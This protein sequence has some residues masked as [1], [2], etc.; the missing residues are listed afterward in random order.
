MGK[1]RLAAC[2]M[3]LSACI[4]L[5]P[6]SSKAATTEGTWLFGDDVAVNTFDCNYPFCG[7]VVWT[8]VQ[9]PEQCGKTVVWGLAR[10]GQ[11]KWDDGHF[12]DPGDG[13]TYDLTVLRLADGKIEAKL[14]NPVDLSGRT[15]T[16]TPIEPHSLTGWCPDQPGE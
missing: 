1:G 8:R 2:V 9:S 14:V 3:G 16:V 4:A 10:Q 6:Q 13:E 11:N 15:E 7:R 5:S 12:R